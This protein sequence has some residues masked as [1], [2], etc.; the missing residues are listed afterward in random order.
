[1]LEQI[2]EFMGKSAAS[3]LQMQQAMLKYWTQDWLSPQ[4]AS[5]GLSA[6]LGGA[7]RKQ[8]LE[9][10][11]EA[12]NKHR[13]ALDS[14]YR[15]GIETMAKACRVPEA[16]SSEDALRAGEDVWRGLFDACKSQFET[17]SRE[18]Q[19]WTERLMDTARKTQ[20]GQAAG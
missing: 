3:S 6:E 18:V 10:T 17:Q 13:E 16:T 20:T 4:P 14:M 2:I 11:L 1:M 12:L 15:V 5:A 19:S 8:G 9:L 7:A